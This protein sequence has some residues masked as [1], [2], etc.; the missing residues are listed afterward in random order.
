MRVI[1]LDLGS[2]RIGAA[3]C[4]DLEISVKPL[5]TIRRSSL[6]RDLD[7]L[8]RMVEEHQAEAVVVGL[9]LRMDGSEGDAARGAR[10]FA[11]ALRR[12]LTI[13]VTFQDER[14]TSY[15][16]ENMMIELGY[17]RSRRR[18]RSDEFAAMIILKD[19]LTSRIAP[20]T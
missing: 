18:E 1:A 9:P 7:R 5:E 3:V 11:D 10:R 20:R 15:E 16:A 6:D 12:K 17:D 13:D 8:T 2:K 14:L 19:F 4:D